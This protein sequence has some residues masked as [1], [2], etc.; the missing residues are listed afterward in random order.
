[1][2]LKF[3]E[4]KE[5]KTERRPFIIHSNPKTVMIIA[6]NMSTVRD[7]LGQVGFNA[8]INGIQTV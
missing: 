2:L 3:M 5:K 7:H 6:I 1:M 8:Y 4:E